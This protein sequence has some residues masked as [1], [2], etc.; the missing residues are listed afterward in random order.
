MDEIL[1]QN[2]ALLKSKQTT[3]LETEKQARYIDKKVE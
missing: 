1:M 2:E 3:G